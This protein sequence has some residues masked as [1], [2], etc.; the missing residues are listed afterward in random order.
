KSPDARYQTVA[1]MLSDLRLE[2]TKTYSFETGFTGSRTTDKTVQ[3]RTLKAKNLVRSAF[4]LLSRRPRM[5]MGMITLLILDGD[6]LGTLRN[7]LL[8]Q[9][10]LHK[11]S[12]E[13]SRFF[14]QA[15]DGIRDGEIQKSNE[16][17]EKVVKLDDRFELAHARLAE[18]YMELG[19][20]SKAA[21]HLAQVS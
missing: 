6:M 20:T 3:E 5:Y 21:Y 19:Y 4:T 11:P 2:R 16:L 12:D 8:F 18:T 13:V 7:G 1:E 17:L 14:D 10:K 9:T 15:E